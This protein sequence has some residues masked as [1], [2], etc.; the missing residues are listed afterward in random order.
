MSLA[1]RRVIIV[2][3][4]SGIGAAV[5]ACVIAAQGH[6]VIAGRTQARLDD[7]VA[8]L[9][10]SASA[11]PVDFS[12]EA[13]VQRFYHQVGRFDHLV[14]TA[15]SAVA[16]GAIGE[17]DAVKLRAALDNKLVG[18]WT[19]VRLGLP[20]MATDGAITLVGGAAGRMA[21]P[22]TAALAAINAGV[23]AMGQTLAVELAPRRVNS[24]SPGL[25]A[26]EAYD[27][28]PA[29]D[30]EAM[31]TSAASRLP[32]RRIGQPGDLAAAILLTLTNPYL[33]GA[34][35][36]IDGGGRLAR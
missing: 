24:V 15:S 29:P 20:Q 23:H 25:V 5:A 35:L 11:A 18:Y 28:M 19:M 6:A 32:A 30:R 36:D 10:Q 14:L 33:T 4:A 31:F 1:N 3:G 8:Q 27:W 34:I 17:I 16:W 2:G 12:D 7:A 26:T 21:M 13:S 22:G 9:G